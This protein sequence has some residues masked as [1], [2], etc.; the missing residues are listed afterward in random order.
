MLGFKRFVA[1]DR[2]RE[3][4]FLR[5]YGFAERNPTLETENDDSESEG[6]EQDQGD[7]TPVNAS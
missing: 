2:R 7:E 1:E 6:D 4:N 3:G 5:M